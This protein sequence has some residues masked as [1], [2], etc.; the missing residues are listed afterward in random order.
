MSRKVN[1]KFDIYK[2]KACLKRNVLRHDSKIESGIK[3]HKP[4]PKTSLYSMS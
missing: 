3:H 1:V 2:R 4:K